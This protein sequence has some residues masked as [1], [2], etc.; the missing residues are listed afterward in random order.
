MIL[1]I[2]NL[3]PRSNLVKNCDMLQFLL[4]LALSANQT[5]YFMNKVLGID[6]L[7]TELQIRASL[8]STLKCYSIFINFGTHSKW[9]MPILNI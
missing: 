3:A 4:N 5:C 8:A 7:N 2:A 1:E 6:D 9:N